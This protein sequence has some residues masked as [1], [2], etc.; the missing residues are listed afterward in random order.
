M[1]IIENPVFIAI[2]L[3]SL[4]ALAFILFAIYI[5]RAEEIKRLNKIIA[6]K[7]AT[8][9][10]LSRESTDAALQHTAD[11]G[12][13]SEKVLRAEKKSDD[14]AVGYEKKLRAAQNRTKQQKELADQIARAAGKLKGADAA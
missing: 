9:D 1:S 14:V 13:L 8:I 3:T 6:E 4:I 5:P 12:E 2:A 7:D 10:R 11:V